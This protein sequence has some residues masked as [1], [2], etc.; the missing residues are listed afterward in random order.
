MSVSP[1]TFSYSSME[2]ISWLMAGT[3]QMQK[4]RKAEKS[5]KEERG[6]WLKFWKEKGAQNNGEAISYS[7]SGLRT[8]KFA[9][10]F[11]KYLL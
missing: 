8:Q 2:H 7:Y 11:N 3:K 9:H 5:E 10:S 4:Q 1:I 6:R